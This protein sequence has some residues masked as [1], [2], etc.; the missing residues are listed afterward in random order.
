MK[1]LKI[2]LKFEIQIVFLTAIGGHICMTNRL[3]KFIFL[4]YLTFI[5]FKVR[6][7]KRLFFCISRRLQLKK[8]S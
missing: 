3:Y 2:L 6:Q 7:S 4:D 5:F 8:T 1:N